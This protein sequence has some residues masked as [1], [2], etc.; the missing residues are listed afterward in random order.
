MITIIETKQK[1]Y[2]DISDD[3]KSGMIHIVCMSINGLTHLNIYSIDFNIP[4]ELVNR[5]VELVNANKET[6]TFFP[7]ANL[8]ILPISEGS[9]Q[10]SRE[11]MKNCIKDVFVA[12][13]KYSKCKIIYFTLESHY[14]DKKLALE[15]I[16]EIISSERNTRDLFVETIWYEI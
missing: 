4:P 10:L 16:K 1:D 5:S 9:S 7:T 12:N 3:I 13:Q 14:I 2:F 15:V 6:G 8:S 11:E